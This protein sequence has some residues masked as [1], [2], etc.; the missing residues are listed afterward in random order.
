MKEIW[1]PKGDESIQRIYDALLEALQTASDADQCRGILSSLDMPYGP[2][3]A[4]SAPQRVKR[5]LVN[6]ALTERCYQIQLKANPQGQSP[7]QG[8]SQ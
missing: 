8:V 5:S 1:P 3:E 7:K 4:E 6:Q 2:P